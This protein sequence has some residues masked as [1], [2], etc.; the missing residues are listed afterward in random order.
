MTAPNLDT[1]LFT[2]LRGEEL[3]KRVKSE[4][5]SLGVDDLKWRAL[6]DVHDANTRISATG[7]EMHAVW[8]P[9]QIGDAL[10]ITPDFLRLPVLSQEKLFLDSLFG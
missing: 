6:V 10:M 1:L 4:P 5:I 9:G 7:S 2:G 3:S 8:S